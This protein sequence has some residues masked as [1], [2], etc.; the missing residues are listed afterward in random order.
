[1]GFMF[2]SRSKELSPQEAQVRD[3]LA[4]EQAMR[5]AAQ[6]GGQADAEAHRLAV[7][8]AFLIFV[9]LAAAF[10][11][12]SFLPGLHDAPLHLRGVAGALLFSAKPPALTG[13]PFGDIALAA[14]AK[15]LAV[16]LF[17][18]AVPMGARVW[19]GMRDNAKGSPYI[20][21]WGTTA[22]LPFLWF[23]LKDFLWPILADI[24]SIFT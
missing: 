20:V 15:A 24:I 7:R 18:G 14:S 12:L 19:G 13:V 16:C 9:F 3:L 10:A 1:M 11:G 17:A 2:G 8:T 5:D 21:F 4:R 23:F 22:A 6:P